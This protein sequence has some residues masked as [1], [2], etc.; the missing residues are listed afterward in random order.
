MKPMN[1]KIL[2]LEK[3]RVSPAPNI[4]VLNSTTIRVNSIM[5]NWYKKPPQKAFSL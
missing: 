4:I 2:Q 3:E 1:P 5:I